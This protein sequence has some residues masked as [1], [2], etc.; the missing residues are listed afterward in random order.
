MTFSELRAAAHLYDEA[1][2][3]LLSATPQPLWG[4]ELELRHYELTL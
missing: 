4:R 1:G 2:F 3:E